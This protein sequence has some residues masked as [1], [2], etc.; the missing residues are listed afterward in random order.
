MPCISDA[1]GL[2]IDISRIVSQ[3]QTGLCLSPGDGESI[4]TLKTSVSSE[5]PNPVPSIELLTLPPPLWLLI[6]ETQLPAEG[7]FQKILKES[8]I[9]GAHSP[10]VP[11]RTQPWDALGGDFPTGA[12]QRKKLPWPV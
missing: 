8:V 5:H 2:C 3:T 10:L 4:V 7:G 9:S 6:Q 12:G 11:A 1:P